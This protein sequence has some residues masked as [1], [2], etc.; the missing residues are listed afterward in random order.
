MNYLLQST[1]QTL[2]GE[3]HLDG[4]KSISNRALIIRALCPNNFD[5]HHLSTSD[6]T[7]ALLAG[8]ETSG[9]TIDVGAAGTTMRFLTALC[10]C[11]PDK[12]TLLTGSARMKQRPIGILV[13]ALKKLGA[14]I[15]YPENEGYPPLL[16]KGKKLAGGPLEMEAGVSSQYLSAML[17]IAPTLEKGLQLTL[18]GDLVSRPY[19]EMTLKLMERFGVKHN[20][21]NN[22]ISI[23]P[24][25]YQAN[26]FTVEADWSAASYHY[27][28]AALADG[29]NIRLNGLFEDSLQGDSALAEM[30]KPLGIIS[31]F[32]DGFVDLEK[33]AA[34]TDFFDYNF[35]ECPD[36]AQTLAVICAGL[37]I[38]A[39]FTG[40][41]T[42]AIKETD[43]T[44]A[45]QTELA[46]INT[47][48]S[49]ENNGWNLVATDKF[50]RK[51]PTIATYHDHR[52][53]MAFAPL[54]MV[55]LNGVSIEDP[56]VVTKSYGQFYEDLKSLG[57]HYS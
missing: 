16:I 28:L 20:W 42:L 50:T 27:A 18:V 38:N 12:T 51:T 36:L 56:M 43:R 6:D 30:M 13:D 4:S 44:A 34:T 3:I 17:M 46:K 19:L 23:A 48:F 52:M 33:K 54:A 29:A 40:L 7:K 8:L 35:L 49:E 26:D 53:A 45:L 25:T 41:Q 32:G 11:T 9:E 39:R 55:L 57:I 2:S 37:K 31:T 14:D 24:Q 21:T 5:I 22:T 15:S 47:H 1:T 10:A